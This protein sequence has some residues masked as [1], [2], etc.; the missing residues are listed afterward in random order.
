MWVI[1]PRQRE[2]STPFFLAIASPSAAALAAAMTWGTVKQ[3]VTFVE[4]PFEVRWRT[5]STPSMLAG[6]LT[7]TLGR[8][9]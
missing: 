5:T 2:V 9:A 6:T 1:T 4:M 3:T 7:M 8:K